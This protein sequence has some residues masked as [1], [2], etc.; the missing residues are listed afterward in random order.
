MRS[1]KEYTQRYHSQ[2]QWMTTTASTAHTTCFSRTKFCC[3][4]LPYLLNFT[5]SPHFQLWQDHSYFVKW[6][7]CFFHHITLNNILVADHYFWNRITRLQSAS[8]QPDSTVNSNELFV[9]TCI[10]NWMCHNY[11]IS[12]V[13][14]KKCFL[15]LTCNIGLWPHSRSKGIRNINFT[16][17]HV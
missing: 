15:C 8:F 12:L 9:D 3:Y 13:M 7:E 17:S 1:L 6:L 16:M 14:I 4:Y 10:L 2:H 11:I 5:I